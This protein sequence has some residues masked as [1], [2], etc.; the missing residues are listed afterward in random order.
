MEQPQVPTCLKSNYNKYFH[1]FPM[2]KSVIMRV[3]LSDCSQGKK[4]ALDVPSLAV[5]KAGLDEALSALV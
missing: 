1:N 5:V 4:E 2:I 3:I